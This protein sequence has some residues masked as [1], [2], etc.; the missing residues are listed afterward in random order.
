MAP[1]RGVPAARRAPS[2]SWRATIERNE[3]PGA[4]IQSAAAGPT[5]LGSPGAPGAN[6]DDL[7]VVR[8]VLDGDRDAFRILVEREAASIIR[9][10]QRILGDLHEAEDVAQEAFV[11]AYR[12][13][14]TW[15]GDGPFGA[16]LSRIAVRDAVR[17]AKRRR[18]VT[19]TSPEP[20]GETQSGADAVVGGSSGRSAADPAVNLIQTERTAAIRLA[21]SRLDE[22]YRETIALRFFAERSLN[23]IAAETGRPLA[24]VKTHLRRGLLRLRERLAEGEHL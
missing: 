19:W 9:A 6:D 23:E 11:I 1:D 17:R 7:A 20:M 5:A 16:W 21:V 14:G 10:C 18:E 22:P 4:T 2:S 24:T 12:S 13:L 3:P 8:A 15:R